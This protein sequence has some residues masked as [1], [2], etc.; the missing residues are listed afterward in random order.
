MTKNLIEIKNLCKKFYLKNCDIVVLDKINFALKE[1]SI[2][3]ITG[4]SGSGKSTFLNIIGLLDS[5]FDGKYF[6]NNKDM[7]NYN[8]NKLSPSTQKTYKKINQI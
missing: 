7:F 8:K 3:S 2:V 6:F 5:D 4:P 1:N